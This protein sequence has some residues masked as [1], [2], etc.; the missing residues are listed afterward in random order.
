MK[1]YIVNYIWCECDAEKE[2]RVTARNAADAYFAAM[3]EL[4]WSPYGA[5][6]EGYITKDGRHHIFTQNMIGKAY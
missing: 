6:V 4:N 5:Y 3:E 1:T 2:I